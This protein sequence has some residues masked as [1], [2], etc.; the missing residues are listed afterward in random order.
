MLTQVLLLCNKSE[1]NKNM[2]AGEVCHLLSGHIEL[3][4]TGTC[5][6]QLLLSPIS[7]WGLAPGLPLWPK[8]FW[9]SLRDNQD[10]GPLNP[11]SIHTLM[12]R[13]NTKG[14]ALL[15]AHSLCLQPE[16]CSSSCEVNMCFTMVF[17]LFCFFDFSMFT[18]RFELHSC[19]SPAGGRFGGQVPLTTLMGTP[20]PS[21]ILYP[22]TL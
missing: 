16:C 18:E 5:A 12:G 9:L 11:A 17:V 4:P 1:L 3:D 20:V 6:V 21:T 15:V 13:L 10:V 8:I 14:L 2:L 19:C 7:P 22:I